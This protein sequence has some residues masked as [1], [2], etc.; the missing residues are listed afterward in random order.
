MEV[1]A[2]TPRQIAAALKLASRR[3]RRELAEQL[4]IQTMAARGEPKAVEEQF[5]ELIR[6]GE[7]T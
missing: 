5:A 6:P 1:W 2:M 7:V 4:N 3:H